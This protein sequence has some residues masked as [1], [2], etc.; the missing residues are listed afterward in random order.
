MV[1]KNLAIVFI[2]LFL[3]TMFTV[4][5]SAERRTEFPV[6][7]AGGTGSRFDIASISITNFYI[8]SVYDTPDGN[9]K[10]AEYKLWKRHLR[11]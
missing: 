2:S 10:R 5:T 1:K 9:L 8:T 11:G 7:L 4:T 6:Y 3:I